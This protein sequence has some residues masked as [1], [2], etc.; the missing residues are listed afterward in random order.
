MEAASIALGKVVDQLDA[1][2]N[3]WM[4]WAV[5]KQSCRGGNFRGQV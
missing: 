3:R 1:L 4:S 2:S 5:P